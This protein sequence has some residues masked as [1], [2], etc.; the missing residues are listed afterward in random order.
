M[1]HTD[2]TPYEVPQVPMLIVHTWPSLTGRMSIRGEPGVL[3]G[4]Q[5][6]CLARPELN[7]PTGGVG[8]EAVNRTLQTFSWRIRT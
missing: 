3:I 5:P 1:C 4:Y 7:N 8:T 2:Q 6:Q